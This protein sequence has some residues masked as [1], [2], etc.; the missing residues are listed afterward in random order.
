MRGFWLLGLGCCVVGCF[1]CSPQPKCA[2]LDCT[3][4]IAET[5][6]Q[7]QAAG[8]ACGPPSGQS[9]VD[10]CEGDLEADCS[11]S[12]SNAL[13]N[14]TGCYGATTACAGAAKTIQGCFAAQTLTSGCR[15]AVQAQI[16]AFLP[17]GG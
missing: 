3:Q 6:T 13:A 16:H 4:N 1:G 9:T 11:E 15:S 17:D 10:S 5:C 7:L 14:A 12:E 8:D 2:Y